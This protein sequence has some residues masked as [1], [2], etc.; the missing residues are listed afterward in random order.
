METME[1]VV[2]LDN[3]ATTACAPE[4]LAVMTQALS[5]ACG[6][7]SSHYSVGYEAKEFVDTG[8]AQV[9]KAIN[10]SP[11][12]IFFTGCGSEADNWAVKGTAFTKARQNK[13]H[14][15]T[16][17]FEHHA[18]MHSMAA[19]ERMGFEVTYIKP[20][21]E[22]YIRP[23]DVE[24]A[25]RP[26]TALVSIMMANNEIGT[27][28]PIK[29]IAEIAHKHG[30]WMHTDAVQ[31]VGTIP[32]DVKELGVDML[33]MSAH[34]FNGPKGMGAL[35]IRRGT[36]LPAL[37][38][39][40]HQERDHRAGTENV[41]GIVGMGK[42]AELAKEEIPDETFRKSRMRNY[43]REMIEGTIPE[44]HCNSINVYTLPGTLNFSFA[45]VESEAL[46]MMMDSLGVACSG[47]SACTSMDL[48]PSHV[49]K[50][51]DVDEKWLHGSVRFSFGRETGKAQV[52]EVV[53]R[54]SVAVQRLR[55]MNPL[56]K[57][58]ANG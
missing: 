21:P 10:A 20:T 17:A 7:P 54:L 36:I 33:S 9:A 27:I 8:R 16:S 44:A 12:E 29:E 30:V 40:G 2:Y 28:Q 23:E 3:A 24:A 47:G 34:K 38:L 19:L 46:V 1:K 22:G 50:A 31:A 14:L 25:I 18:I 6:N 4:V 37:I 48:E 53:K 51:M 13:K 15:I 42:A 41:P 5:G 32:V 35:Y 57:D 39:G 11:A 56:W 52:D 26:D 43:M 49:L 58:E 55:E 45:G